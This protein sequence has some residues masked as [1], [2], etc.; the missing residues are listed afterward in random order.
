MAKTSNVW[1]G[2]TIGLDVGDRSSCLCVLD[3]D[4][5]IVEESKVPT[6]PKAIEARFGSQQSSRVVLETGTHANWL[7]DALE[8]LGHEVIVAD[9]RRL[10]AISDGDRKD[11][12]RDAE[13]LARLG[14]SDTRLLSPV[15]PRAPEARKDL[16][17][18][19]ARAKLVV[20]RTM[21]VN[22]IRGVVKSFGLRM[23]DC[24]A[25]RL[26]KRALPPE[27][28]HELATMMVMLESTSAA[29]DAY[30]AKIAELVEAKYPQTAVLK[31]V[32]GVGP[33]TSLCFV[34]TVGDPRRFKDTRDVGPYL[35]MTPKKHQSGA[36]DPKLRITKSGDS[37][38]R[39]LLV[40]SAQ[41]LLRRS[42][43]DCDLKRFGTRLAL[44]GGNYSKQRAVIAT[45]R[46]LSVLLL[47]MWK[48]GEVYEPLHASPQVKRKR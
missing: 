35:G 14:R 22:H 13:T 36:K 27:L 32:R 42:S 1:Q 11:D 45:A 7:H 34:L 46:K 6:T 44:R 17:V 21:L 8:A 12:R 19:R 2:M 10:R 18:L 41:H 38:M 31:Q 25:E 28:S 29:I 16:E 26:H 39:T 3:A 30:D 37:M 47:A 5:E 15:D 43:P 48:T 23:P 9:A 4:G 24:S 40:Q 20:I 33:I